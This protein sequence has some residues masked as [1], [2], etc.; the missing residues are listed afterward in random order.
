MLK[1]VTKLHCIAASSFMS[2]NY[3]KELYVTNP[4]L[5][6]FLFGLGGEILGSE[7]RI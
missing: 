2:P 4:G 5:E 1:G 3:L 6:N 7:V